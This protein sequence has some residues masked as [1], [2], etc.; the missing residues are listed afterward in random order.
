[1]VE[2]FRF[3]LHSE[4]FTI[5]SDLI[6]RNGFLKLQFCAAFV[7]LLRHNL[8]VLFETF[9]KLRIWSSNSILLWDFLYVL[10]FLNV[11][12]DPASN[13]LWVQFCANQLVRNFIELFDFALQIHLLFLCESVLLLLLFQGLFLL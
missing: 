12:K 9:G 6:L 11:F 4:H 1:M 2:L 10:Y 13:S 3:S 8:K 7:N 5:R